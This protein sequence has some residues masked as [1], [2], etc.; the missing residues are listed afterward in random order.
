M[1]S[2]LFK[3]TSSIIQVLGMIFA[4]FATFIFT[5]KLSDY[6]PKDLGRDFAV[7]GK[8]SAGKPRG[9]NNTV[10]TAKTRINIT[11]A[12]TMCVHI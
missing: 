4:F 9:A 12:I 11:I 5:S 3:D 1:L 7:N 6:L 10:V 2:L 8:Q